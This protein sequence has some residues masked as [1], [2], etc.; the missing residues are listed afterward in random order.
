LRQTVIRKAEGPGWLGID[1]KDSALS[2]QRYLNEDEV[3]AVTA[4]RDK[5]V[6][7]FPEADFR[8]G[9]TKASAE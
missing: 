2:K 7:Y 3:K 1:A 4:R 6:R 5:I 8:K 9:E